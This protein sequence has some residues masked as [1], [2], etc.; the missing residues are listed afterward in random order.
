ME[1][2][3][4]EAERKRDDERRHREA[5]RI[6]FEQRREEERKRREQLER[7]L[8][9]LV[10]ENKR[11]RAMADEAQRNTTIRTE[12]QKLGVMKVDLAYRAV[13]DGVVRTDDGRLV[14]RGDNGDQPVAE[15]LASLLSA[16]S[17]DRLLRWVGAFESSVPDAAQRHDDYLG[18]VLYEELTDSQGP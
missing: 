5:E 2:E 8:N 12:L 14:A 16:S 11:S 17:Q 18:Q 15:Y 9:E 6:A 13:Q 10:E 3:R 4:L 1:A 7:R